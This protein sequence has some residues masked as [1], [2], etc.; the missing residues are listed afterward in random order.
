MTAIQLLFTWVAV[1]SIGAFC[2]YWLDKKLAKKDKRR[3]PERVLLTWSILGGAPGAVLAMVAFRHKIRFPTFWLVQ[4]SALS[5]WG[6]VAYQ[7]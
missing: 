7:L 6:W 1:L 2:A 3:V 5:L 4:M